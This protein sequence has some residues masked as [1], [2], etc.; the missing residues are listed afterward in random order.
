[1]AAL[2]HACIV[3]RP[4]A[5]RSGWI[6]ACGC[7]LAVYCKAWRVRNTDGRFAKDQFTLDFDSGQLTCPA[8]GGHAVRARQD[9]RARYAR[10]LGTR[11]NLFDLRR[12][13]VATISAS[14]PASPSLIVTS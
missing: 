7:D 3:R 11:K 13:A 1:M 10:Y 12:V 4:A 6:R 2:V 14:L 5:Q 8:G 9:R